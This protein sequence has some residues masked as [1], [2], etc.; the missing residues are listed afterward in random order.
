MC[1][2]ELGWG[3]VGTNLL[4]RRK[5]KVRPGSE[6]FKKKKR[7]WREEG[8]E[9]GPISGCHTKPISE[10]LFPERRGKKSGRGGGRFGRPPCVRPKGDTQNPGEGGGGVLLGTRESLV[11]GSR[12]KRNSYG[13]LFDYS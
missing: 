11:K 6:S 4:N 5:T 7:G 2:R 10:S 1:L 8:V 9:E 13:L 12:G 3:W